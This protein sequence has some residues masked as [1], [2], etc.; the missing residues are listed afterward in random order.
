MV[1]KRKMSDVCAVKNGTDCLQCSS[2][3]ARLGIKILEDYGGGGGFNF[4]ICEKCLRDLLTRIE[5]RE[6]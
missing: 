6:I 3:E 5:E 2:R 1:A 4:F